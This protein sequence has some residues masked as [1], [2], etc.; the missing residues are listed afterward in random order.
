LFDNVTEENLEE[1]HST[2][3]ARLMRMIEDM[4]VV[5][6][7][8]LYTI[9]LLESARLMHQGVTGSAVPDLVDCLLG[10]QVRIES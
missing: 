9:D 10:Q 5:D 1:E 7:Q 8:R 3:N 2:R 4:Y 6:N